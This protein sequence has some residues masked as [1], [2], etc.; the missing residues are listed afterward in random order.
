LPPAS[1]LLPYTP[2]FRST[3]RHAQA[4]PVQGD[5]D[6]GCVP[7]GHAAQL[8][9]RGVVV[10]GVAGL[11]DPLGVDLPLGGTQA[12]I[13]PLADNRDVRLD[14]KSTRLNSSHVK[15]S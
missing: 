7:D 9:G 2:L 1:P 3:A 15:I 14:R 10:D 5:L 11:G 6:I 8:D 13:V 12:G 4:Q